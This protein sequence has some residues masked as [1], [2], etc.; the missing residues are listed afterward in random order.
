MSYH[1]KSGSGLYLKSGFR[2]YF[3]KSF[4]WRVDIWTW[5]IFP[6]DFDL[7]SVLNLYFSK[8][9]FVWRV[10]EE[11]TLQRIH[12][13]KRGSSTFVEDDRLEYIGQRGIS[14]SGSYQ[15]GYSTA[16]N[17]Q[18]HIKVVCNGYILIHV[19]NWNPQRIPKTL[20]SEGR[21][22]ALYDTRRKPICMLV[23]CTRV[24]ITTFWHGFWLR[25]VQPLSGRW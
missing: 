14:L 21:T 22:S 9:I 4:I 15:Q 6:S 19:L 7:K 20:P 1:L 25:G 13:Y 11:P 18:S 2:L 24:N 12:A 17:T 16:Y 8:L 3:S 10:S 23:K 5:C